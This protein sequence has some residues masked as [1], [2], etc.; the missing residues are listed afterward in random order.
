MN[1]AAAE[2]L[3]VEAALRESEE[4]ARSILECATESYVEFDADTHIVEW[5]PRAAEVFGWSR[6]EALGRAMCETIVPPRLRAEY[7]VGICHAL[8]TDSAVTVRQRLEIVAQRRGGAEFPAEI[9]IWS[10]PCRG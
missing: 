7:K 8:F 10:A 4:H 1:R 5:N 6:A 2:Q 3:R 9:V